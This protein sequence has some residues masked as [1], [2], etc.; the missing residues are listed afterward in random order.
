MKRMLCAAVAATLMG[1]PLAAQETTQQTVLGASGDSVYSVRVVGANG[2]SYNC[3]PN[4]ETV[5]GQLVRRCQRLN[6]VNGQLLGG[7]LTTGAAVA[8]AAIVLLAL[9]ADNST[10]TTTN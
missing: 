7:S 9:A 10:T 1:A 2:E 4:I 3:R 8:G 5:G 6:V